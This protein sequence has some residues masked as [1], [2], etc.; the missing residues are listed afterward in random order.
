MYNMA[1][2]WGNLP[3]VS[4]ISVD[5]NLYNS[6]S[7]TEEQYKFA[8]S[9]LDNLY[10]NPRQPNYYFTQKAVNILKAEIYLALGMKDKAKS[11]LD[12]V[13]DEDVFIL[14]NEQEKNDIEIYSTEYIAYLRDE[15]SG[16]DNSSKWYANRKDYYG[17]FAALKRLGKIQSLTGIDSHY[18]LLP[19]PSN[20][21]YKYSNWSQNPGY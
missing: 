19:I 17:T 16:V 2:Q 18:N 12:E 20:E 4:Q 21:L 14:R 5:A 9:L 10:I 8:L 11:V 13:S 6:P 7:S 15:A 3:I 1:T